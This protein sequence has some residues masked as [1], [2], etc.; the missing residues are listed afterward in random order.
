MP[1]R[2]PRANDGGQYRRSSRLSVRATLQGRARRARG[3]IRDGVDSPNPRQRGVARTIRRLG[4]VEHQSWG[5]LCDTDGHNWNLDCGRNSSFA[6]TAVPAYELVSPA[7]HSCFLAW[8]SPCLCHLVLFP[9]SGLGPSRCR[10]TRNPCLH[11]CEQDFR[12]K[13][14][15]MHCHLPREYA[16]TSMYNPV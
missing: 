2:S 10:E 5:S 16:L 4:G 9:K 15:E 14:S 12:T 13:L 11:Q 6:E 3:D 8:A 1:S 7:D